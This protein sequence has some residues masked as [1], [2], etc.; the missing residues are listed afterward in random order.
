MDLSQITTREFLRRA[1]ENCMLR[2]LP[3]EIGTMDSNLVV[4]AN[5]N[6]LTTIPAST[7]KSQVEKWDLGGNPIDSTEMEHLTKRFDLQL[8]KIQHTDSRDL[9]DT[10]VNQK[11]N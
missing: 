7:I 3:E 9:K 1:I 11:Y 5:G 4:L 2:K 10:I 6:L 8:D